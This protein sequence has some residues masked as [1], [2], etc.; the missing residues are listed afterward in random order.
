[1]TRGVLDHLGRATTFVVGKGGVGKTTTAG[2]LALA[3]ADR[4]RP[5]H[6]LSTD[7]AHSLADLFQHPLQPG[8]CPSL[9]TD[10][11]TVEELNAGAEAGA[12][13]VVLEP[14]LR[15]II[16]RGTYLDPEDA[17][18]LLGA[19][20]PA[21]HEIGA[22]LRIKA[23]AE[24]GVRLVVDT[25]PTGHALRL[26][27]T[28]AMVRSWVGVFEAMAAKA[29]AVA[30]ALVGR[31]VRLEGE[32]AI[33]SLAEEMRRFTAVTR[34]ADFVV[35][36]GPGEVEKAETERLLGELRRR[37]LTVAVTVAVAR[38]G[39]VADLLL[40]VR[41]GLAGCEPLR[42]WWREQGERPAERMARTSA[43]RTARRAPPTRLPPFPAPLNRE[44]VVFAGKG[45]VGKTTCAAAT[46]VRLAADGPV[47][48]LS[49]DPAGSLADVIDGAIEDLRVRESDAEA[50]L[51]RLKERYRADVEQVFAAMGLQHSARLDREVVESLWSVAPPGIDELVAIARLADEVP[52]GERLVLDTAP[53]GHFLRL[54]AM[55]DLAL[56]WTH[57]LMRVLLKYRALGGLD[58][59]AGPLLRL[60]RRL[61]ALR[62]RL[63]DPARTSIVVV[64]VDEPMIRA[65]TGRLIQRLAELAL[66][67]A[68]IVVNRGVDGRATWSTEAIPPDIPVLS[69]PTVPEPVGRTALLSFI[70]S[71]ERLG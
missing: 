46:A 59:P 66:P 43:E 32:A 51:E 23:L 12:R 41:P 26:L 71:W 15:E 61:R 9:C 14:A 47:T 69:A 19:A 13:L 68:A 1:V 30:S 34:A 45:G 55:P 8:P 17:D 48:V 31:R 11:L 38:P 21:L 44:L 16:D 10:R 37:E 54:I 53:T 52:A 60:A 3:L 62:E 28:E 70:A 65:E 18:T 29:D 36:A 57:R 56:D 33:E 6:L 2:G 64:T 27:D 67:V 22:A 24:S 25:A 20:L 35:V 4:G 49:A 5:T 39:A 63:S 58:A 50:E 7:P 40:P 42:A